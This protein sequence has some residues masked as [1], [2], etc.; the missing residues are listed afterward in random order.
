[1]KW[2][3]DIDCSRLSAFTDSQ[4]VIPQRVDYSKITRDNVQHFVDRE[5]LFLDPHRKRYVPAT[6]TMRE[7]EH[8][9]ALRLRQCDAGRGLLR[10]DGHRTRVLKFITVD[11]LRPFDPALAYKPFACHEVEDWPDAGERVMI[12][13]KRQ[14]FEAAILVER[15]DKDTRVRM[16]ATVISVPSD[17]VY[18]YN[19]REAETN[20]FYAK[21]ATLSRE[22]RQQQLKFT[23]YEAARGHRRGTPRRWSGPFVRSR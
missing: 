7:N 6:I 14:K 21:L 9:V 23:A 22:E 18:H 2:G 11:R 10:R 16:G 17:S 12:K 20:P 13:T 3:I 1:M 4:I 19:E 8:S 5:V 15:Q